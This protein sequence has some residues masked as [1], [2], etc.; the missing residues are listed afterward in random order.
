MATSVVL[1]RSSEQREPTQ[2]EIVAVEAVGRTP[3]GRREFDLLRH[4]VDGAGDALGDSVLKCEEVGRRAVEAVGPKL[5]AAASVDQVNGDPQQIPLAAQASIQQVVDAEFARCR[6][7]AE[8]LSC[9]VQRTGR[10]DDP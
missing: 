6:P 3:D 10:P 9:R 7:G 4:R 8:G 1:A 5:G 2:V